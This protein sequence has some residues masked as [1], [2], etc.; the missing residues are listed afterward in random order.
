MSTFRKLLSQRLQ[1]AFAAANITL[2]E[3]AVID[4]TN[5][6]D[7]RFGDYQSNAA[8]TVAKALKTNPRQL[9]TTITETFD[10]TGLC[11]K[12][13]VAGPG[14]LNFRLTNEKVAESLNAQVA[15]AHLG[16]PRA[17]QAKTIVVDFSAPN[18]AKPMH[19]GHIRSTF[20]GDSLARLARYVG[21]QVITDNHI[22]DWGTQFGMIIHGWK[23]RMDKDALKKDP[24]HELVR[25]YKNVNAEGKENE[26]VREM[27]KTELVKLQQGD[28]ENLEIWKECVK[29][30]LDQLH[31]VYG[32]LDISFDHYLGESFY[33]DALGPLVE[34]MLAQGQA[35]VSDGAVCV[36]S[37]GAKKQDQDPFLIFKDGEWTALPL[38]IRKADGGF[39][40]GTTDLATVD[41]RVKE[42]KAEEIWYVVGAPQQLHFRQLF[43]AS[44]RRGHQ[45]RMEH[46]AFGSI[47][48]PDGK[49]FKTRSGESV[50]LLEVIDEAVERAAGVVA[51]REGFTDAEKAE[52]AEII[53]IAAVKYAELSQHRMTDYKFSWD[54]MLSLQGN[55][56]PY[57]IN[58]YV[59]TRAI[60]RKLEGA[61]TLTDDVQLT[62]DAERALALKLLQFG[63]AVHDVLEDFRPNLLAQYLYELADTFHTFYEACH[64]L[65]AE[66]TARNT[67]LVLCDATSRVLKEGLGLL[68]IKTTERM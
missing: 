24:I 63:E 30:T 65:R 1:A 57:L 14:F 19:V 5:A 20:I 39:L 12:P 68:G 16:V 8:M 27:C 50:G 26:A 42:W 34:D 49:M 31:D 10:G 62:E 25:V 58:A 15:D 29:L 18:V 11:H 43:D 3:G 13:E 48:G 4:V 61:V 60:F 46:I 40:Y 28:A 56:A 52:V 38:I 41:Y 53:G 21:H 64:V 35:Q 54:K 51:E 32:K 36:F 67:R 33:N 66:G 9:A 6:S 59:R 2:P 22:G 37:D 17:E 23:T 44:R 7:S 45:T 55:T 47:L